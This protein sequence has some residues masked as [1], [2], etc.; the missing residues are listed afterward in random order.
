MRKLRAGQASPFPF[1]FVIESSLCLFLI[2]NC[3]CDVIDYSAGTDIGVICEDGENVIAPVRAAY[4]WKWP[5]AADVPGLASDFAFVDFFFEVPG[6]RPIDSPYRQRIS[7]EWP[8]L[9]MIQ[10]R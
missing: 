6:N 4:A 8:I 2:K 10:A 7:V 1:E 9:T 5:D 3:F